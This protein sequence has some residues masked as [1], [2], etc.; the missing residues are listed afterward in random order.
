MT[1]TPRSKQTVTARIAGNRISQGYLALVAAT[2]VWVVLDGVL[3]H[4]ADGSFAAVWPLLLTAPSSLPVLFLPLGEGAAAMALYGAV[5]PVAA[6]ANAY[7][8]GA[9]VRRVRRGSPAAA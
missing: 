4:H 7:L 8:I 3:V 1:D 9:L 2:L 6:L 5:V